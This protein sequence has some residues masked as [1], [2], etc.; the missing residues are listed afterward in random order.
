[1]RDGSYTHRLRAVIET[2]AKDTIRSAP[3]DVGVGHALGVGRA[4]GGAHGVETGGI[5]GVAV[6]EGSLGYVGDFT[7]VNGGV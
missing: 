3:N 2:N 4:Y 1:M 7:R 5:Y 6:V